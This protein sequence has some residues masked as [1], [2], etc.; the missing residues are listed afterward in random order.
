[1]PTIRR[2]APLLLLLL[3]AAACDETRPRPEPPIAPTPIPTPTIVPTRIEY[4]VTGTHRDVSITYTTSI[5]GTTIVKTDLPWFVTFDTLAARTFVFVQ[6]DGSTFNTIEGSLI[7]QIFVDGALFREARG[8][9]LI[10]SV[11]ASGEVV[12]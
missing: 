10:P 6:A 2:T 7:V 12:R 9:G 8:A 11:V 1:M 4:R 3:L 5:A